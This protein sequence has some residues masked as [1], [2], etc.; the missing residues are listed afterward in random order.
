MKYLTRFIN[1]Q[2]S[3]SLSFRRKR[4][5]FFLS[6]L[7]RSNSSS[8]LD[9]GG[10]PD[11]WKEMNFD[12][13]GGGNHITVLNLEKVIK[14]FKSRFDGILCISGNA[15]SMDSLEDGQF[16]FVFS[17]SVIE[18]VGDLT[19]QNKMA[20]E[21]QRVGKNYFVQTPNFWFPFEHHFLMIGFQ[22]LPVKARAFLLR[23]FNLGWYKKTS[24]YSESIQLAKS[25]RLLTKKEITK[26][27]P[28]ATIMPEK[29]FFLTKSFM[30]YKI[31]TN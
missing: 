16:D 28:K 23:K 3:V 17:N 20:K 8:I 12:A 13:T 21:I 31:T 5:E 27:F 14:S 4:F 25:I 24:D 11:F 19:Q 15:C 9:V 29:F 2:S 7:N 6:L 26:L 30:I 1:S 18:H 22:F 10:R